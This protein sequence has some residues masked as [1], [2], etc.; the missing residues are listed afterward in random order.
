MQH[1]PLFDEP[2]EPA[3]GKDELATALR[4]DFSTKEAVSIS[5]K[6]NF[7]DV[8]LIAMQYDFGGYAK[9]NNRSEH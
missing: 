6:Q 5:K 3:V 7:P 9:A 1:L 2:A 8:A 4:I